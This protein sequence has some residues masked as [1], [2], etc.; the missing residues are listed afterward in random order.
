MDLPDMLEKLAAGTATAEDEQAFGEWIAA[1]PA[2][3]FREVLSAYEEK[4]LVQP[5]QAFEPFNA[6]QL[7]QL[8]EETRPRVVPMYRRGWVKYAVAAVFACVV[9]GAAWLYLGQQKPPVVAV[10]PVSLKD[11]KPGHEGA[12]LT[13]SNNEKIVLDSAGNGELAQQGKVKVVK[14]DGQLVYVGANNEEVF[15]TVSTARGR[16]W[17]LSLPDGTKVW[18]NSASSLRYSLNFSGNTR[19]VALTG[20][21]YFEVAK[22]ARRPFYVHTGSMD[23]KV[24]GTHFNINAYSDEP[25]VKTTLLEGSVQAATAGKSVTITPGQQARLSAS[26]LA[27][28]SDIDTAQVMAWKSGFFEFR[29]MALKDIMRQVSR[30]YDVDIVYEGQPGAEAYGG[31]ISRNVDLATVLKGLEITGVHFRL[32]N[33]RLMVKP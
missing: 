33:N 13:L 29:N 11:V 24:L 4:V 15:N 1:L 7:A 5:P 20:E 18:L 16:Q 32:D 30:W 3:Q 10:Q 9:V 12:V 27:V 22:D 23:V 25:F 14:Q 28:T 31:R 8:L 6:V 21:A 17:S 26:G 2:E 19:E